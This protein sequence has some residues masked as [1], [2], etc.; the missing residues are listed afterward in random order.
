MTR[1]PLA[2]GALTVYELDPPD[3]VSCAAEAGYDMVGMRLLTASDAE[4]KHPLIGDT[5]MIRE[6]ARRLA[7]TGVRLLDIE[8]VRLFPDSDPAA[9]VP[10]LETGARLG[11]TQVMVADYIPEDARFVDKFAALCDLGAPLGLVMNLEPMPWTHAPSL[12]VAARL[13]ESAGRANGGLLVDTLHF[14]RG[15]SVPADIAAVP[16]SR[17]RYFQLCDAPRERPRDNDG[18]LQQARSARLMPGD[19]D[20]DLVAI[21]RAL[22]GDIPVAVEVPMREL[23]KT[24]PAL[25]RARTIRAKTLALLERAGRAAA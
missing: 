6:F 15:D 3:M 13:V 24:V 14:F 22:P 25:E 17:F 16:P 7:D 12:K 5:P 11:A 9:F 23:A 2:L 19:G 20:I 4:P 1:R 18:L 8:L 10:A 21:V